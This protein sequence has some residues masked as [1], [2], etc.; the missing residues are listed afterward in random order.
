MHLQLH[1]QLEDDALLAAAEHI[2]ALAGHAVDGE[3]AHAQLPLAVAKVVALGLRRQRTS[4]ARQLIRQLRKQRLLEQIVRPL[5]DA[6]LL[7]RISALCARWVTSN[8]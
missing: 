7:P 2:G 5:V 1:L 6:L 3:H 8:I 4:S